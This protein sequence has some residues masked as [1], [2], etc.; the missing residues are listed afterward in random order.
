M[1]ALSTMN[2]SA[3]TKHEIEHSGRVSK[4]AFQTINGFFLAIAVIA[5][6]GRIMIRLTIHTHLHLDDYILVFGA[7]AL[8]GATAAIYRFAHFIYV[9]NNLKFHRKAVPTEDDYTAI[10]NAQAIAYALFSLAWTT[11]FSVKLCFLTSFRAMIANVSTRMNVWYW[12]VMALTALCFIISLAEIFVVC[13]YSGSNLL[14]HCTPDVPARKT[15]AMHILVT[16]GD[17]LT[18][19]MIISIPVWILRNV[20]I[21]LRK[22]LTI[23]LFLCPSIAM[24]TTSTL[25]FAAGYFHGKCDLS[26]HFLTLFLQSC[27][28]VIMACVAAFRS[29][30]VEQRRRRDEEAMCLREFNGVL[31]AIPVQRSDVR[32]DRIGKL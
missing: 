31:N 30:F 4:D 28:A 25:R 10:G 6:L 16:S 29:F 18:D 5:L 32:C 11:I 24:I 20:R 14:L 3:A 15:L 1:N 22:K 27:V 26:W 21:R 8:I 19:I 7:F 13:P 9:L 2:Y 12:V 17:I 23:S